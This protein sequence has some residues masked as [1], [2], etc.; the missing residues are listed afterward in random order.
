[1]YTIKVFLTR[2]MLRVTK[3]KCKICKKTRSYLVSLK[4][5]RRFDFQKSN[6]NYEDL[7]TYE[8]GYDKKRRM[9][10]D[11]LKLCQ[12]CKCS[13]VGIK[14]DF[15][16][17]KHIHVCQDCNWNSGWEEGDSFETLK[18]EEKKMGVEA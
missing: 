16:P 4:N 12:E 8:V 6:P 9:Y 7:F 10:I 18:K 3:L 2:K 17:D 11:D 14:H 13:N 5:N 1:M 15:D